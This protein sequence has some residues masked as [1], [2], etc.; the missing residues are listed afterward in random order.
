MAFVV[1]DRPQRAYPQRLQ[2]LFSQG[3]DELDSWWFFSVSEAVCSQEPKTKEI[4]QSSHNNPA[5]CKKI[6]ASVM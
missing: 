6:L 5:L 2:R 1:P 4:T 3:V